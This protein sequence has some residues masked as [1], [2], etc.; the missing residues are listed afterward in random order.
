MSIDICKYYCF[1]Q[2]LHFKEKSRKINNHC[3]KWAGEL[4]DGAG[5]TYVYIAHAVLEN[6]C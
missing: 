6:L 5:K 4:W 1:T 2:P 3:V